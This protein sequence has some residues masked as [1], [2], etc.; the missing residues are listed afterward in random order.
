MLM[1]F[2]IENTGIAAREAAGM[3]GVAKIPVLDDRS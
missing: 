3:D 1:K 2:D